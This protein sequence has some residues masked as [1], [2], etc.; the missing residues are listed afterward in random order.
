MSSSTVKL[1]SIIVHRSILYQDKS[2]LVNEWNLNAVF[3]FSSFLDKVSDIKLT[4]YTPTEQVS[5]LF[6]KLLQKVIQKTNKPVNILSTFLSFVVLIRYILWQ[7][8]R[9]TFTKLLIR[10]VNLNDL[11]MP[12]KNLNGFLSYLFSGLFYLHCHNLWLLAKVYELR[13]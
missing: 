8:S 2:C 1:M 6:K 9:K 13:K 10:C 12:I 4:N 3:L 7:F 11:F 5:I